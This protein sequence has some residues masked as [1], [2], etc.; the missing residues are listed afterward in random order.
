MAIQQSIITVR[1]CTS[2]SRLTKPA[3]VCGVK[4]TPDIRAFHKEIERNSKFDPVDHTHPAATEGQTLSDDVDAKYLEDLL[5]VYVLLGHILSLRQVHGPTLRLASLLLL[6]LL[7]RH[8]FATN[9]RGEPRDGAMPQHCQTNKEGVNAPYHSID[10]RVLFFLALQPNN[11]VQIDERP[12]SL[13][14]N[15]P[16]AFFPCVLSSKNSRSPP[17]S[18]CPNPAQLTAS[19]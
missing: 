19:L 15:E 10:P 12:S 18:P 2:M 3:W 4:M 11:P 9:S 8:L 6:G 7:L 5:G 1:M 13:H 14:R 16:L 17:P